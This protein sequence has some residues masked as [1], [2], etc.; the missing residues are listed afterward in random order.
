MDRSKI[1]WG[2]HWIQLAED[3]DQWWDL[4]NTAINFQVPYNAANF[5]ND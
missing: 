3:T 1:G 5:L 4:V 2:I